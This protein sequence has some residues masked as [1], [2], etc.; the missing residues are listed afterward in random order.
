M[1]TKGNKI[2]IIGAGFVGSTT[3]FALMNGGLAT[4]IVIVD[5]NKNKAEG[6][7]M[8]LSHGV[9]FVR[10]IEITSGEYS[11]TKDSDIVIITAGVGQKPGETR[12]DCISKN[13][14]IFKSI[15]PEV[16]KFSPNSILLVVSNPVDILTYITYK[17][18]GFPSNRVI[19]SGTVLDTSR[20]KYLLSKHFE[21]DARNIHTYIMGE[22]GDS[23]IAAWSITSIAGMNVEEFC[24]TCPN[25]C[26][27]ELKYNIYKEVKEAAYTIIQKKG[28][29]YYAV[30]LAIKRIV[31]AILSNENSILTVS[32]LLK[33]EYGI[34][35]IYMG[36]PTVVGR[37]GVK[38]ILEVNLNEEEKTELFESS[39]VLKEVIKDSKI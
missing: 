20:F 36:V 21:I 7:A 25:K 30:A 6:E 1:R 31:E 35:D 4:E 16:V 8:D 29:T 37:D 17:L 23:E 11:D 5:I 34:N 28:A 38:K 12:L 18:S 22:H 14:K 19:G 39:K 27:G 13:L 2:S 32:S 3:A 24:S 10:P 26:D 15:V 9:S 33:G